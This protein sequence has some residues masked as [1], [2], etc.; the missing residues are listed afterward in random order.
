MNSLQSDK[1]YLQWLA[2]L[3]EQFQKAQIQAAQQVNSELLHYYW[4][5]GAEIVK[6]QTKATWGDGFLKQLSQDL[7][8]AFPDVKGFSLRNLKY[9]RQWHQFYTDKGK[10][11]I[12]QQLVAQLCQVPWGHNIVLMSKCSCVDE[13]L[14][15]LKHS[16][17]Y[18]WSRSVLVHHIESGRWQREGMSLNNFSTT[19]RLG[20]TS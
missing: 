4:R 10:S 20:A 11:V 1:T 3:K 18:G 2:D 16:Q 19:S 13:A 15:Y 12:G 14:Y 8:C 6:Q 7:S 5:L 9:I 17:Q